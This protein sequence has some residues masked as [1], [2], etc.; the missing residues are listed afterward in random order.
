VAVVVA[1][2]IGDDHGPHP[3]EFP[4][5][6]ES[7]PPRQPDHPC[8]PL[9]LRRWSPR[10]MSGA[11]VSR[12]DLL[13]LVEAARWAPSGGNGQPWRFV[14]ALGDDPVFPAFRDVVDPVNRLWCDRAGALVL[15]LSRAR[16][17]DGKPAGSHAFDAG[18]AWLAFALQG[19]LS[20]LVVHG[21]AGFDH[22]R[23]ATLVGAPDDL[24]VQLMIAVGHPGDPALLEPRFREREFP[25]GREPVA[26]FAFAGRLPPA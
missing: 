23:A 2:A 10:A 24:A 6:A 17:P 18:A 19:T 16:R 22:A 13:T 11:P 5:T 12:A 9:F 14:Y 7:P 8:D 3:P 20:G 25:S 15:L 26:G 1:P 4:V 21:M